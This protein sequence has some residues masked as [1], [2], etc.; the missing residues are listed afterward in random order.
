VSEGDGREK[1]EDATSETDVERE[2]NKQQQQQ[3]EL[4]SR[5]K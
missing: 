3:G 5:D 2:R 4:M 1:G